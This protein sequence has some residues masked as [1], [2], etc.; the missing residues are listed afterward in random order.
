M[1]SWWHAMASVLLIRTLL[2]LLTDSFRIACFFLLQRRCCLFWWPYWN[3][4]GSGS[5]KTKTRFVQTQL[6]ILWI[7]FVL[8]NGLHLCFLYRYFT[9]THSL[10]LSVGHVCGC[11]YPGAQFPK[12]PGW[13]VT[14][15][16]DF[17]FF[18]L[19]RRCWGFVMGQQNCTHTH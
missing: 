11:S 7:L 8:I 16:Q 9:A 2:Y 5:S 14:T 17:L 13:W 15:H 1:F 19:F 18:D 12:E 3:Y 4:S 10:S 6:N